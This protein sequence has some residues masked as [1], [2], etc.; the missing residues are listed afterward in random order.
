VS[1]RVALGLL[2]L[3]G[4]VLT[5]AGLWFSSHL[6]SEGS[7]TFTARPGAGRLVVLEPSVLNRV[8]SSVT[9]TA[10]AEPGTEVWMGRAA[11]SD[12]RAL[13]GEAARQSV[14]GVSLTDWAL[15]TASSGDG[16]AA[17]LGQADVWR[18]STAGKGGATLTVS[19]ADAPETVVI[20]SASGR[21]V[22]LTSLEVT[23]QRN[24]W[25]LQSLALIIGGLLLAAVGV[26]GL[27]LPRRRHRSD[28]SGRR[29]RRVSPAGS[30]ANTPGATREGPVARH[31]A[32]GGDQR[33]DTVVLPGAARSTRED[34]VVLP[35]STTTDDKEERA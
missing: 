19:Q 12:A 8:D 13:V 32:V 20:G 29:A 7:A 27:W 9:I 14:T 16:D 24:A 33:Q 22:E 25:A 31:P 1:K 30:S 28:A 26:A 17:V 21:P 15:R 11:P 10:K 6:G 3:V 35:H 2:T 4:L 34:T 5:G 23:W 18:Q